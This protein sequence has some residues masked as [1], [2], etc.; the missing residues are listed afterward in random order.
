VIR[1]DLLSLWGIGA[2]WLKKYGSSPD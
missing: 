1:R 2:A